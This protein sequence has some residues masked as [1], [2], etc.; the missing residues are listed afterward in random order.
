MAILNRYATF[1]TNR[2]DIDFPDMYD[3]AV[4]SEAYGDEIREA[5]EAAIEKIL[6]AERK[7]NSDYKF[8]LQQ[9]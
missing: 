4:L 6:K 1:W 8:Y 2:E 9:C 5:T 7:S 3:I